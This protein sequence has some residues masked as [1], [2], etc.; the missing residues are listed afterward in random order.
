MSSGHLSAEQSE[1]Y[2][3]QISLSGIGPAGQQRL[4]QARVLVI[5]LGGLGSPVALYLAAAGIGQLELVDY[6][7]VDNSNLQRQIIHR[8]NTVGRFKVDSAKEQLLE[9][10]P[11]IQVAVRTQALEGQALQSAVDAA[12]VVVECTD[13]LASRFEVNAACVKAATPLVSGGV[14]QFEGQV[15]VFDVRDPGSPCLQC[16]HAPVQEGEGETCSRVGVLAAAPGV[17]G[18]LQAVEA[19]KV[20]LNLPTLTGTLLLVDLLHNDY[21]K[22]KIPRNPRCP[23]CGTRV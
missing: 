8:S 14:M 17:I 3:R 22:I 1:R 13:N 18:S 21:H 15:T 2:S 12:D 10:N 9:L 7:I 20:L 5:G 6:D 11:D 4:L 16:L 23:V 19:L